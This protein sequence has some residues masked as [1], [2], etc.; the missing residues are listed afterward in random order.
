MNF[1]L[2]SLTDQT[3]SLNF[4]ERGFRLNLVV[5]QL[6]IVISSGNLK[7]RK[8]ELLGP[9]N[10]ASRLGMDVSARQVRQNNT[11]YAVA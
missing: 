11:R 6:I 9:E 3:E 2:I 1:C 8:V 10:G 4:D 7:L 5:F